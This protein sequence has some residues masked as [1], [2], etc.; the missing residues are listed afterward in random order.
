M[1]SEMNMVDKKNMLTLLFKVNECRI[2][3]GYMCDHT[4]LTMPLMI[5]QDGVQVSLT[6]RAVLFMQMVHTTSYG[7]LFFYHSKQFIGL[8]KVDS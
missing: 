7:F 2:L 3:V 1:K 6:Y 8:M 5:M 4:K